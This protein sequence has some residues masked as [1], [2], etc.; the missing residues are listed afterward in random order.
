[1]DRYLSRFGVWALAKAFLSSAGAMPQPSIII[2]QT[3]LFFAMIRFYP[4]IKRPHRNWLL[5]GILKV[6]LQSFWF[7]S[8][9]SSTNNN[10]IINVHISISW[11]GSLLGTMQRLNKPQNTSPP[12]LQFFSGNPLET[13]VVKA[14]QRLE[15]CQHGRKSL[16]IV[17]CSSPFI[18]GIFCL[19]GRW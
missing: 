8:S 6:V 1:M 3:G 17:H 19:T 16:P 14:V 11:V 13:L 9:W 5:D 2:R 18:I 15:F 12:V 4:P 10:Y 7:A